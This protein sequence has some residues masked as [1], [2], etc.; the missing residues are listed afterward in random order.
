MRALLSGTVLAVSSKE[1]IVLLGI[2]KKNLLQSLQKTT[3]TVAQR[4]T[5]IK[6][7][8]KGRSFHP[9]ILQRTALKLLAKLQTTQPLTR[10]LTIRA[11]KS[12]R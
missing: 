5:V 9:L 3:G 12:F 2:Q 10:L 1:F 6:R 4:V 8:K 11:I 7:K